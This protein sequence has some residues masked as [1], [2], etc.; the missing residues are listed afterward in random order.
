MPTWTALSFQ[1]R[2]STTMEQ[3][4]FF[5]DHS[6]I[7]L[8][9][10]TIL[11]LYII[12]S[13][14][15][16][17]RFNKFISEGQE[18]ETIWTIL[19][20]AILIF[21]ALPSIKAL[22]MIEENISPNLSIKCIGHQWYW[23]YEY[24]D[25]TETQFDRFIESP[26]IPRLLKTTQI[27]HIPVNS[28]TRILVTSSDVIHAWAIPSIGVK[29]DALPG[30]LNQ[31]FILPKRTGIYNGQCSEICGVNHSFIPINLEVETINKIKKIITKI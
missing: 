18:I 22:Y 19:P 23:S 25:F 6:I 1:D 13:S 28:R 10:I 5:H 30:R 3:L 27:L 8:V 29:A 21:I 2:N 11:T 16:R 24:S 7:I 17:K 9:T 14:I 20:S 26:S 31:L 12:A 15:V 4:E